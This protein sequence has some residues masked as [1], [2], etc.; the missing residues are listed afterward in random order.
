MPSGSGGE[1]APYVSSTSEAHAWQ[2]GITLGKGVLEIGAGTWMI[3]SGLVVIFPVTMSLAASL[4]VA[5]ASDVGVGTMNLFSHYNQSASTVQATHDASAW[6]SVSGM[7]VGLG[8]ILLGANGQQAQAFASF[9]SALGSAPTSI[10][11]SIL[12]LSYG[13][14]DLLSLSSATQDLINALSKPSS[15]TPQDTSSREGAAAYR[16][17]GR[18]NGQEG[19]GEQGSFGGIFE[20]AGPSY[21]WSDNDTS[22]GGSGGGAIDEP[23]LFPVLL[24]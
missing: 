1:R 22:G 12:G 7:G 21:D 20:G 11:T 19:R 13:A 15:S 6:L 8:S 23:F 17:E 4:I 10:P 3:T 24:A 14:N 16:G 9:G 18:E 5:G 2:D